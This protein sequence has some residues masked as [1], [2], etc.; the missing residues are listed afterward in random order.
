MVYSYRIYLIRDSELN[1]FSPATYGRGLGE[2]LSVQLS[3]LIYKTLNNQTEKY[4]YT[5][6]LVHEIHEKHEQ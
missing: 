6:L 1:L 2:G 3:F 4:I 5:K